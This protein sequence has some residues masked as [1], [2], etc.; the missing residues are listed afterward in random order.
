L[1]LIIIMSLSFQCMLDTMSHASTYHIEKGWKFIQSSPTPKRHLKRFLT[2]LTRDDDDIDSRVLAL[3]WIESRLRPNIP[4]GDRGKACGMF[5]I[6]ARY[7]YP[8]FR[9]K[10][11]F[12]GWVEEDEKLTISRECQRLES[13]R[14]S[15]DTLERLLVLMDKKDLHP[16][17]HNSGFYGKCNTWYKER[18]DYWISY[19][20]LAKYVCDNERTIDIMAMMRTGNPIP[21]A[22]ANMMQGYLDAMGGKEPQNKDTVYRSGYDLAKLVQEGKATAPAWAT[23]DSQSSLNTT[24]TS[25]EGDE[26]EG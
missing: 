8:M 24:S 10:R 11:G 7:S 13:I 19:F 18:L 26:R 25:S 15:V 23:E 12:V 2:H 1:N 9:R 17:H 5:Q 22:P 3:S 6:H 21:T 20:D 4:R 14:Y 16:C